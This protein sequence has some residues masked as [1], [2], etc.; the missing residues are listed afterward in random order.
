MFFRF[1]SGA[2]SYI[3]DRTQGRLD[4]WY[5][6]HLSQ[7]GKEVLLKST[8]GGIPVFPM[9]CFSLPKTLISNLSSV[10]ADFWWGTYAHK[11]KIHW[12]SWKKMCL[13][14]NLGGMGFIDLECFNMDL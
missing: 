6:Q 3:K 7:G 11:K 14:K 13:P 9:K 1:K 4:G 12:V 2:F 10:M 8:A 5:L